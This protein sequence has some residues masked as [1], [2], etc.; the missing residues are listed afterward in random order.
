M[1][2]SITPGV[3][4][5][6]H[7]PV[8]ATE[9]SREMPRLLAPPPFARRV[10]GV[11]RGV[12]AEP[13]RLSLRIA[14][15]HRGRFALPGRCVSY[16][17]PPRLR[18]Y[19]DPLATA[20]RRRLAEIHGCSIDQVF[21]GNGSDE[22]LALATRAF[23]EDDGSIGY[24]VPSYSLYPV[25]AEIRQAKQR[26]APLTADYGWNLPQDYA[27][28]LFFLTNPNAPTSL[29]YDKNLDFFKHMILP[30]ITSAFYSLATPLL[31]MRTSMLE[32]VKEDYIEMAYAKGLKEKITAVP[33][34]HPAVCPRSDPV[35][36]SG[37]APSRPASRTGPSVPVPCLL[38]SPSASRR[39]RPLVSGTPAWG[40]TAAR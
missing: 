25:L 8:R 28:S 31:V 4:S 11:G 30:T 40:A 38:S 32:V 19:P 17:S 27:A 26:P 16:A 23:V 35:D 39:S 6:L 22:I 29:Q 24:F 1:G 34:V 7:S 36:S 14:A 2:A 5:F 9:W 13:L 33:G 12:P 18:R 21:A 10:S 20:V 3:A 37:R 15:A